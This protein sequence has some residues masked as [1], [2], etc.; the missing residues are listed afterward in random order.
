MELKKDIV[1]LSMQQHS[2][3]SSAKPTAFC[4]CGQEPQN[5]HCHPGIVQVWIPTVRASNGG[6]GEIQRHLPKSE[7]IAIK[8]KSTRKSDLWKLWRQLME[9]FEPVCL[10]VWNIH[11]MLCPSLQHEGS[12]M[13]HGWYTS[14]ARVLSEIVPGEGGRE[15][16]CHFPLRIEQTAERLRNPPESIFFT[17]YSFN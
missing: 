6:H 12:R 17:I 11:P 5:V 8:D 10:L 3:I 2:Q 13:E 9:D 14:G 1:F 15:R 16:E 7:Q 4:W